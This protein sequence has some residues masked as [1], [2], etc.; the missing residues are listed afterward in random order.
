MRD[1]GKWGRAGSGDEGWLDFHSCFSPVIARSE[2][3]ACGEPV[4]PWQSHKE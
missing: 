3:T 1:G 2:A 4:E